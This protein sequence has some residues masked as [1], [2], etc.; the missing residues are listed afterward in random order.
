MPRLKDSTSATAMET[1]E[2]QCGHNQFLF[3]MWGVAICRTRSSNI[4]SPLVPQA[5]EDRLTSDQVRSADIRIKYGYRRRKHISASSNLTL[6]QRKT[7]LRCV[8]TAKLWKLVLWQW[9]KSYSSCHDNSGIQKFTHLDKRGSLSLLN[10]FYGMRWK[11]ASR[12]HGHSPDEWRLEGHQCAVMEIC[13]AR[14]S[15]EVCWICSLGYGQNGSTSA[16]RV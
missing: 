6:V 14:S 1:D 5:A 9:S 16:K 12:R 13:R 8:A 2:A 10:F 15:W 11:R 4:R 3:R 7:I